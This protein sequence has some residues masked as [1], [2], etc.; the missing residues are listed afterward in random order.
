M[1]AGKGHVVDF[2]LLGH[3]PR[4]LGRDDHHFVVVDGQAA[5]GLQGWHVPLPEQVEQVRQRPEARLEPR[6][7]GRQRDG[8]E[9]GTA[10]LGGGNTV[11]EGGKSTF[12]YRYIIYREKW[13][14]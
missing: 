9:E 1:H 8:V 14:F 2:L 10:E 6:A 12:R 7:R 4:Q 13:T 11:E 5:L 3:M